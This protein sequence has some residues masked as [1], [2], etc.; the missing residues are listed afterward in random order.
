M[1]EYARKECM[2]SKRIIK[3]REACAEENAPWF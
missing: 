2:P 3:Q 1:H